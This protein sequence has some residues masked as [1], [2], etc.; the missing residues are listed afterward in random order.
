MGKRLGTLALCVWVASVMAGPLAYAGDPTLIAWWKLNDGTGDVAA[1]SS[2]NG[3]NGTIKNP[4][5]GLGAGGSVWVNDPER[6]MV[7]SFNGNDGSGAYIVTDLIVP[8]QTLDN[9]FTWIF[10]AKQPAAQATNNDTILGNRYGGTSSPLQFTKFT[11]TRF[12]NYNDDGSYLNGINYTSI[13]SD[14]WVHHAVVKDGASLTY[15]RNGEVLLT[16]TMTK[17]MATNPFYMGADGFSGAQ[18]NWQGYLSDVRLYT[19]ALPEKEVKRVMAG[20]GPNAELAGEPSPENE[21]TDVPQDAVLGWTSGEFA[22]THNVYFGTTFDDVNGASVAD[23]RGV[24]ASEGLTD[25]AFDPDGLLEFGQTYYWRIDEVNAAPDNTVFKGETWSFTAE[26][27]SYPV[28]PAAATASNFQ[29]GM[30]PENTINGSG[31]NDQDEHGMALPTMWMTT[32]GLPA[33][34]QYEFDKVYTLD[35]MLVWNSNQIIES[36]MGFGAKGVAV[37][38]S[39]D[40]QTWTTL[41]G[42]TEFAKAPGAATYTANTTVEFGGAMAKFV[43]ITINTNWGGMAPQ[44][45][46]SEVRFYYIPVQ[47]FQPDPASGVTDV[48]VET[49]LGWRPGRGAT[50]HTVYIGADREAVANGTVAGA[51]ADGHSYTPSSLDVAT[52]YFWKVDETGD[53][54]TYAGDV[55]NFTTQEFIAIDDFESYNDD[56]D[57]GT[58]I[59]NAWVD[60]LTNGASG[61]QVGYDE[62][63]FAE[64]T[65]V[66]GGKQAMPLI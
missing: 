44:T 42:A 23:P 14:V 43:K 57:A 54:G 3:H 51:A 48:S 41:E 13:P 60:G 21:A 9:D 33:W 20:S 49:T 5:A 6:G 66:H 29:N 61:S 53:A 56:V 50:S 58:T 30:G 46:L 32:G 27:Y 17:T 38:Y 31:L 52:T 4:A 39:E 34:V 25:A 15:Y 65:V 26:P 16:N 62:S 24:L 2:G 63:P 45:G 11:P 36:F 55:W 64:R 1:D 22:A 8:A 40:G 18:E 19:R 59:W 12:E 10:W 7:V 47:A 28:T 37:E 35:K